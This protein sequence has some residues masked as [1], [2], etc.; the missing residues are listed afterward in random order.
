MR[1]Y[2]P[3]PID[4]L[5]ASPLARG[6]AS[7]Y[8]LTAHSLNAKALTSSARAMFRETRRPY[9]ISMSSAS[10]AEDR[11]SSESRAPQKWRA[12]GAA[13]G[14]VGP[15]NRRV[16]FPGSASWPS[17]PSQFALGSRQLCLAGFAGK[18]VVILKVSDPRPAARRAER[19]PPSSLRAWPRSSSQQIRVHTVEAG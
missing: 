5:R 3:P 1:F 9:R 11:L 17:R 7:G 19:V 12:I 10:L 18:G 15:L 14:A 2:D 16:P 8:T 6:C 13:A 4:P